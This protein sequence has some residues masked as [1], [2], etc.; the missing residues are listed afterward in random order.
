MLRVLD[1]G[2]LFSVKKPD[3]MEIYLNNKKIGRFTGVFQSDNIEIA[4][5]LVEDLEFDVRTGL[6]MRPLQLLELCSHGTS[7]RKLP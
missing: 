2:S 7:T 6:T 1:T 5:G 3:R 4:N